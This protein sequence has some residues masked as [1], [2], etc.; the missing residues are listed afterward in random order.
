MHVNPL[1]EKRKHA[2]FVCFCFALIY[3]IEEIFFGEKT[4]GD[5]DFEDGDDFFGGGD[6][7]PDKDDG[8]DGDED[9]FVCF[10]GCLVY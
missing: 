9:L 8:D 7:K 6:G 4:R 3:F 1:R 10:F 5:D 2:L